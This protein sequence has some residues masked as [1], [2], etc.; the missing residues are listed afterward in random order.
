MKYKNGGPVRLY[1][2]VDQNTGDVETVEP[3]RLSVAR[4]WQKLDAKRGLDRK[5]VRYVQKEGNK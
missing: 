4:K 1:V 5:V 3:N 2:L